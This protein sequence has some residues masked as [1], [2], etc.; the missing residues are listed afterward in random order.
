MLQG[1]RSDTDADFLDTRPALPESSEAAL[2]A[3][4]TART[5]VA[6]A[7]RFTEEARGAVRIVRSLAVTWK[8]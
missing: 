1:F 6:T 2:R 7:L 3:L 8:V 5:A 4:A